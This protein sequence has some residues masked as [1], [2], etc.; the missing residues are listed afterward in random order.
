[1]GR[2]TCVVDAK[3]VCGK[4]EVL[5]E[6]DIEGDK[7]EWFMNEADRFYYYEAY[8]SASESFL[9]PPPQARAT[10]KKGKVSRAEL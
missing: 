10:G 4:C 6:E 2:G 3:T 7:D 8:D 9:D 1:M 5:Y